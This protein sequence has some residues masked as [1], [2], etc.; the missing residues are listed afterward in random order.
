MIE[1]APYLYYEIF[2]TPKGHAHNDLL[3]FFVIGGVFSAFLF[4]SFYF[5]AI[6]TALKGYKLD[7]RAIGIPIIYISGFFQCYLLDDEVTLPFFAL[8]GLMGGKY[9]PSNSGIRKMLMFLLLPV[10]FSLGYLYFANKTPIADI[11]IHRTRDAKNFLFPLAQSTLRGQSVRVNLEKE[12]FFYFKLEGCLNQ[13]RNFKKRFGFREEPIRF[14]LLRRE[15]EPLVPYPEKV[16]IELRQRDAFDQDQRFQ[17][18]GEEIIDTRE[19][20]LDPWQESFAIALPKIKNEDLKFYDLGI[21]Y[22]PAKGNQSIQ[23]PELQIKP[24]CD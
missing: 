10:F 22:F 2:I 8:V 7:I 11:F 12:P 19:F 14:R 17:A 5:R 6:Q 24:N 16:R 18:H 3:H 4:L 15:K 20:S 13:S 9:T 21:A 23:L 1:S